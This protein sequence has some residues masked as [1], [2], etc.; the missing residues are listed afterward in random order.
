GS[1]HIYAKSQ[2]CAP[3]LVLKSQ[4]N[5]LG[6]ILPECLG[7]PRGTLRAHSPTTVF[8]IAEMG[9]RNGKSF[10]KNRQAFF[11]VDK[12]CFD[13]AIFRDDVNSPVC[14]TESN[15]SVLPEIVTQG[16]SVGRRRGERRSILGSVQ[17][18]HPA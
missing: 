11:F 14:L 15:C 18:K 17:Q 12:R 8:N 6:L 5:E 3:N 13:R 2:S 7:E 16:A 9:A 4:A 10:R 1:V